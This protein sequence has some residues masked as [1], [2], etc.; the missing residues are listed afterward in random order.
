MNNINC[1]TCSSG[2][3]KQR[4]SDQ[5]T[6]CLVRVYENIYVKVKGQ[7]PRDSFVLQP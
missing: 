7:L 5:L 3:E 6:Q 1:I 4:S 2:A